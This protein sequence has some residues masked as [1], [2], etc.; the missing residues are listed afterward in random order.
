MLEVRLDVIDELGGIAGVG[1]SHMVRRLE[2]SHECSRR[3]SKTRLS[4][5]E[6]T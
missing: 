3:L 2:M 4:E 6:V 5:E 1:D